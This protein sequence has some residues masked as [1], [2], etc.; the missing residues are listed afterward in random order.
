MFVLGYATAVVVMLGFSLFVYSI[1][2]TI[3]EI[4]TGCGGKI[5]KRVC[6]TYKSYKRKKQ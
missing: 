2:D 1:G 4:K 6:D 3:W 5:G